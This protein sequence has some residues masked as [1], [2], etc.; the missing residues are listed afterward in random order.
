MS[1]LDKVIDKA[2]DEAIAEVDI[3]SAVDEALSDSKGQI[4]NVE[5]TCSDPEFSKQLKIVRSV[6]EEIYNIYVRENLNTN[7]ISRVECEL[8]R[9]VEYNTR[10]A[11]IQEEK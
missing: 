7:M 4:K 2:V 6:A 11:N 10:A 1:E 9:L 3:D 8:H 5:A